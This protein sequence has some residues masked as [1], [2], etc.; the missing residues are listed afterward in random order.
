ME[1]GEDEWHRKKEKTGGM[2]E[3]ERRGKQPELVDE[4]TR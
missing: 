4:E 2:T 3:K 1:R